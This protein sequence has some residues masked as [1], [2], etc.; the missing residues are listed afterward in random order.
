MFNKNF[1][2]LQINDSLFP[3][4]AYSHSY[5]LE[6]YIQKDLLKGEDSIREY[7]NNKIKYS[8]ANTELLGAKLA[9]EN[10]CNM[11]K[12]EELDN[13]LT[14][15]KSPVEIRQASLKM[16]SRFL[17]TINK[18]NLNLQYDYFNNYI[19]ME[20]TQKHHCI[21]YGVLCCSANI[22][23]KTML[24]NFLYSQVSAMITNCVKLVP[25]SQNIG[26]KL[27]YDTFDIMENTVCDVIEMSEDMFCASTPAFDIR[28][29]EHERLYSRLYM[30]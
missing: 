26:Q 9:Y 15:S 27:L 7:I 3:I 11:E 21:A 12:I 20:Y 14:V 6:T 13:I 4:G 18:C 22:S 30:S 23:I 16:G 8:L 25:L 24:N 17:K 10:A 29:M 19:N 28:C 2:L 1:L 5:G